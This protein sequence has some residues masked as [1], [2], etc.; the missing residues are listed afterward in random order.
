[1]RSLHQYA[2]ELNKIGKR[3]FK[4]QYGKPV[5]LGVGMVA[6]V[7]AGATRG[8]NGTMKMSVVTDVEQIG[9]LNGRAWL[10][11]KGPDGPMGPAI[12]VG[13]S[14]YNDM[15]I[16]DYT[17]S[18]R[19]CQFRYEPGR[20]LLSDLDSLNGTFHNGQ[21]LEADA[22]AKIRPGDTIVIGRFLFEFVEG[23]DFFARVEQALKDR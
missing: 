23:A 8:P 7:L 5:L 9:S 10:I 2:I 3:E 4:L 21:L 1:V 6:E 15:V 14:A 17:I 13:R 11:T 22:R 18:E 16:A 20:I 19:H 12:T